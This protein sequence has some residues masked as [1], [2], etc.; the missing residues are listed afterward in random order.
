[1]DI[2]EKRL[3]SSK[4]EAEL[5][6]LLAED[7]RANFDL[8]VLA[9]E[10]ELKKFVGIQYNWYS[11]EDIVQEVFIKAYQS[12]ENVPSERIRRW[13]LRSWLYQIAR[14]HVL[15]LRR[16]E[17]LK[18]VSINEP[19][20]MELLDISSNGQSPP[21]DEVVGRREEYANLYEYIRRLPEYQRV[22]IYLHYI[23][24][25]E[26]KE[27]AMILKKPFNTVKSHGMRGFIQ[28]RKMMVQEGGVGKIY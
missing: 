27:I 16:D 22:P 3:Q 18:T 1:M 5:A 24:S 19:E 23:E 2:H 14:N 15:N 26:Y 20:G 21:P 11:A 25:M 10:D 28:L 17:K 6:S 8:L 9:Y 7:L 4:Q 13:K 12:F